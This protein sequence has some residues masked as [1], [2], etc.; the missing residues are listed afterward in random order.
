MFEERK[1]EQDGGFSPL[2]RSNPAEQLV[3]SPHAEPYY[4]PV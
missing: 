4:S 2:N 1:R 3:L